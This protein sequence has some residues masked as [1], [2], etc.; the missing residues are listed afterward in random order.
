MEPKKQ[1]NKTSLGKIY[2]SPKISNEDNHK[3]Q[4]PGH[5][6]LALKLAIKE[7]YL[8]G[9][10]YLNTA[11]G[12]NLF[13]SYRTGC[14]RSEL[15]QDHSVKTT[16]ESQWDTFPLFTFFSELCVTKPEQEAI[17]VPPLYTMAKQNPL[18]RKGQTEPKCS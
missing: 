13:N 4:E 16:S 10:G 11:R 18:K 15:L 9:L 1:L 8:H 2:D 7:G 17:L 3:P 6:L 12:I 5:L 14:K